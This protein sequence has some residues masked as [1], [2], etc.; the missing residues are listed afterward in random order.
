MS[1]VF[2][3]EPLM[4]GKVPVTWVGEEFFLNNEIFSCSLVSFVVKKTVTDALRR[5]GMGI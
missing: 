4:D 3:P 1:A 2:E 5:M